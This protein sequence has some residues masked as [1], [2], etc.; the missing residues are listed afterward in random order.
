MGIGCF[1][2][3]EILAPDLPSDRIAE[4]FPLLSFAP[5]SIWGLLEG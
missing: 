5:L 1:F 2:T 3:L 4:C